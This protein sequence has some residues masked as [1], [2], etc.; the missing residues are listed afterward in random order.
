[1]SHRIWTVAWPGSPASNRSPKTSR[2]ANANAFAASLLVPKE[3][4][5]LFLKALNKGGASRRNFH[6]YDVTTESDVMET[7]RRTLASTQTIT[8]QDAAQILDIPVGTVMS[9]LHR[10]RRILKKQLADV[11]VKEE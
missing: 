11:A 6:V 3:G 5:E 8:Y 9:R 10:G 1:M 2:P 7:E 4:V